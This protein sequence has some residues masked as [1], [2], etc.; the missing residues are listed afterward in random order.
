MITFDEMFNAVCNS[1]DNPPVLVDGKELPGFPSDDLQVNTTGNA[2]VATLKEAFVFYQDCVETFEN[3]GS[4]INHEHSLLDFGVGW[5]RIARFFL[6]DLPLENIYGLDVVNEFASLCCTLF[7]SNNFCVTTPFPPTTIADEKFNYIVGFSVFSHLSESACLSW[8]KEFHR[9]LTPGGVIA[10][11]T[12]G[13]PFFDLCESLKGKGHTGYTEALSVMFDDFAAERD[14]YD[15]GEFIHSN[16]EGLNG[17]PMTSDFYGETLI[18]FAYAKQAY[19]E[20]FSL[21]KFLFDPSRHTHPIMF[22]SK[23]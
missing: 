6:R 1:Y 9:L 5:G 22:F 18:P 20:W 4:P 3:L 2:G 13:R 16:R 8:M 11:T 12:R 15:K 10:L 14:R 21:E 17:G 7:K 23:K 19:S